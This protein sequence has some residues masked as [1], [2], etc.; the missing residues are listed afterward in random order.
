MDNANVSSA[1]PGARCLHR[2]RDDLYC[3]L[4]SADKFNT[5]AVNVAL[6]GSSAWRSLDGGRDVI[7]PLRWWLM[8]G[9]PL[10]SVF[11]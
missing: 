7:A 2:Y 10:S 6:T 5:P 1:R 8:C 3:F 4:V 9:L 11:L